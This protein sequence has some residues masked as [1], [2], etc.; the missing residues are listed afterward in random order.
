[1]RISVRLKFW[2]VILFVVVVGLL[3]GG[4]YAKSD[5]MPFLFFG[6]I[7]IGNVLAFWVRCP[8]CGASVSFQGKRTANGTHYAGY[9]NRQCMKCG[10]D[11]TKA[12]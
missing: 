2:L 10:C 4:V 6:W 3:I 5:Y 1:M 12:S 11:F 7:L 9:A 8:N